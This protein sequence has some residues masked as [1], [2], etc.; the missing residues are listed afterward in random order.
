MK[1]QGEEREESVRTPA[2]GAAAAAA[3]EAGVSLA[4]STA[5]LFVTASSSG[6][7]LISVSKAPIP[8]FHSFSSRFWKA[9]AV[10]AKDVAQAV[11]PA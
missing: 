1:Y 7:G 11:S 2:Q 5:P 6:C 4:P 8:A 3:A 9:A 10:A